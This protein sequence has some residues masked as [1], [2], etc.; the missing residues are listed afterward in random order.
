MLGH[1]CRLRCGQKATLW[2]IL[3]DAGLMI[4]EIG[5]RIWTVAQRWGVAEGQLAL[6]SKMI[7]SQIINRVMR[8]YIDGRVD[9]TAA[10]AAMN[11]ELAT[12]E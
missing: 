1:F 5:W 8:D 9:A 7:N 4:D 10:V 3:Y 6:A 12:I 2:A 11:A